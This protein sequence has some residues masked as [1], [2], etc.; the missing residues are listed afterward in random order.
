VEP[1][2]EPDVGMWRHRVRLF[3]HGVLGQFRRF[4]G[5]AKTQ[6]LRDTRL[7]G[8]PWDPHPSRAAGGP[9]PSG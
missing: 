5:S 6:N 4:S 8:Y 2:R 9:R 3:D 1:S 7:T